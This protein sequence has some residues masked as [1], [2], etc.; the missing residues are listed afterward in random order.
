M[1]RLLSTSIGRLRILGILEGISL[2]VLL[3]IA[4][5][6]KYILGNPALVRSVGMAHG[7]LF[8]LFVLYTIMAS[9][10][11]S[12]KFGSVTAKLLVGCVLPFGSFYVDKKILS[13]M[14]H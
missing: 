12:W 1:N 6:V 7:V 11:N 8:V 14:P 5:P 3:G 10:S 13:K 4:M 2:L 9:I